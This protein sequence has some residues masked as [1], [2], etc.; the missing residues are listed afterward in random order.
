[1]SV[2]K[3]EAGDKPTINGFAK[4]VSGSS[5][6]DKLSPQEEKS[7]FFPFPGKNN[8]FIQDVSPGKT[9]WNSLETSMWETPE[10]RGS[11]HLHRKKQKFWLQNQMVRT[12]LFELGSF[13]KNTWA[14]FWGDAIFP[15]FSVGYPS[16]SRL[17]SHHVKFYGLISQM[18]TSGDLKSGDCLFSLPPRNFNK[19]S[20]PP[21]EKLTQ[22]PMG[23]T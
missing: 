1:M 7:P 10:T 11:Y 12:L 6:S 2:T 15:P 17:P 21:P 18:P 5:V 3:Q 13:R 22:P 16:C 19:T 14:V 4:R 9:T 8:K 20:P 23:M